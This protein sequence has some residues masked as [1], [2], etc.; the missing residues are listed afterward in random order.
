MIARYISGLTIWALAAHLSAQP[1][2]TNSTPMLGHAANSGGCMAV[3]DMDGDGL[4]DVV[5]LHNSKQVF[6]LYQ[7]ADGSYTTVS[8]GSVSNSSQW[9][10]AVADIDHDGHKDIVSGGNYD[11]THLVRISARGQYTLSQLPGPNIYQQC[12]SMADVDGNRHADVFA[13]ND[14]GAPNLLLT[15]NNGNPQYAPSY[16]NWAT[17][18]PSDMSGNY[19]SCFTDVDNDGNLDL[20]IAHCRQGVN[21]PD[22]PRRWNR[23]FMNDGNGNWTDEAAARG[24]QDH[25]QTWSVDFGDMDND[26]DLDMVAVEHSTTMQLFEN[27]GTGHFTNV[28]VGSGLGATSFPLQVVFRDMDNDGFLDVLVAGGSE[29]YY[30][31]NG[32][33]TFT[34]VQGLF[35]Y[36]KAMHSF[37]FG[38][39]NRDGF[40]D[41]YANYGNG[42]VDASSSNPDILWLNTPNGNHFFRVRLIGTTS[43]P[44]AIGARVTIHGPWGTQ[45][46]EVRSGESYGIVNSF[47]LHFGLGRETVVPSMTVRWPSGLEETYTGLNA[48]QMITL[49]EGTCISPNVA[50]TGSPATVLCTGGGP[51]TLTA[52]DATAYTWN[53]GTSGASISVATPGNYYVMAGEG[54]CITQA[55]VHVALDPDETPLVMVDGPT[56]ICPADQVLL[57]S[58]PAA[59]YNW[60]DG[61]TEQSIA[62]NA[63]GTYTVTVQGACAEFTSA[64]VVVSLHDAPNAPLA[65]GVT[66]P[67]AGTAE[68]VAT[69]DSILWY[70]VAVGGTPIGAGSPW[71]TPWVDANTTF[72]CADVGQSGGQP[73]YGGKVNKSNAGAYQN[74]ATYYLYFTAAQDMVLRSVKVYAN[75][76]AYRTIGIID[77]AT[78]SVIT[79]GVFSIPDGES[80]VQLDWTVPAGAYGLRVISGDPQLWRDGVGSNPSFPYDLAG[81]GAI[82]GTNASSQQYYYFFYDWEVSGPDVWCEGVRTAVD[83]LVGPTG[84]RGVEGVRPFSVYPNPA[85]EEV[86]I[87]GELP[88]GARDVEFVDVSGRTCLRA[89]IAPGTS[90]VD[91]RQLAP[92]SYTVRVR[93][94][95]GEVHT[96]FIKQ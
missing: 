35:P 26:G 42:Y 38:D 9:G 76:A 45:I 55:N 59:S 85:K 27:D 12:M 4:D 8:Y 17:T 19:G 74:N 96:A 90:A 46:R 78:G 83:V 64:P 43:N 3:V 67:A 2:F 7:E 34:P 53:T 39:L 47:T 91:V 30:K 20:Y 56:T 61:S 22:D 11:G 28:S 5:Q 75:G 1:T 33:G 25:E 24:V 92:G 87:R 84:V 18:P 60:S 66:L 54:S 94:A 49:V 89:P 10:W 79:S 37:A 95:H 40:E 80:R 63:A 93:G 6:I 82:T 58:S 73:Q 31:G 70:D 16:I 88:A 65:S 62:V 50:I 72:W 48:D 57:T 14:V 86:T 15:D 41:V 68:L 51:I 44:D 77:Q 29:F 71:T 36:S 69:G 32:D 52:S 13:C 21:N 81:L 23:L